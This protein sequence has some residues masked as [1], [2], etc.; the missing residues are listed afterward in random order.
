MMRIT[1]AVMLV[2]LTLAGIARAAPQSVL[3]EAKA[4][5]T[6]TVLQE[7]L[8]EVGAQVDEDQPLVYVRTGLTGRTVVAARSR[9]KGVVRDVLVRPGQRVELGDILVRIEPR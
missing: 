1:A 6:G 2:L 8:V 3:Q 9:W 4:T 5:I 7:G